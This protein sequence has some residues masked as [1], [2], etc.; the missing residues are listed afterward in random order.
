MIL[1]LPV[2]LTLS[3]YTVGNPFFS[4]KVVEV[5][6]IN[7]LIGNE[8]FRAFYGREP[9]IDDDE[10]LRIATHL[11]YVETLL[12]S[13]NASHLPTHLQHARK[14]NLN[15]LREYRLRGEFPRNYDRAER[16]PCFIDRDRRICA[17]GYLVEQTAGRDVAEGV[18]ESYKYAYISE[19]EGN[20]IAA[21]VANSGFTLE[22][23]ATIQPTYAFRVNPSTVGI[24]AG[25]EG[26]LNRDFMPSLLYGVPAATTQSGFGNGLYG[27]L[28]LDLA[29][30]PTIGNMGG[31][32][33]FLGKFYL[34]VRPSI[35][36]RTSTFSDQGNPATGII[37]ND[38]VKGLR[39]QY[40]GNVHYMQANL[41]ALVGYYIGRSRLNARLQAAIGPTVSIGGVFGDNRTERLS[42]PGAYFVDEEHPILS[43]VIGNKQLADGGVGDVPAFRFGLKAGL[44]YHGLDFGKWLYLVPSVWYTHDITPMVSGSD[45]RVHSLQVGLDW[46]LPESVF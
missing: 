10:D 26:L 14:H 4:E 25:W 3:F 43:G 46:Q 5:A 11:A 42:L 13:R 36:Y 41:D 18:N 22:E 2:L 24:V 38:T 39:T 32:G 44:R 1:C 23:V 21:W 35:S 28:F 15:L 27:G 9:N 12:R 6:S 31:Y 45:W 8:S 30:K 7:A 40:Y 19:M 20:N 34:H 37:G 17:V 29:L 16:R 33:D